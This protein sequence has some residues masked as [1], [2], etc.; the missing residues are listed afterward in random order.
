[1]LSV[2]QALRYPFSS[3]ETRNRFWI[4]LLLSF[5]PFLGSFLIGPLA[6]AAVSVVTV[7][8]NDSSPLASGEILE[9]SFRALL[10]GLLSLLYL[11]PAVGLLPVIG[12]SFYRG[13]NVTVPG[14]L[15]I[16]Y[17]L[18]VLAAWPLAQL[19]AVTTKNVWNALHLPRLVQLGFK[20]HAS[21]LMK[22]LAVSC[23]LVILKILAWIFA[24]GGLGILLVPVNAYTEYVFQYLLAVTYAEA[25][26]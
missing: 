17:L 6:T 7:E 9:R 14:I 19:H 12:F 20:G 23:L 8:R 13:G 18:L 10:A 25:V 1:M 22:V 5:V 15:L 24:L 26:H 16:I 3:T 21:T 2:K 11:L 4:L